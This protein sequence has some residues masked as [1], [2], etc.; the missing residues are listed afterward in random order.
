[1]RLYAPVLRPCVRPLPLCR[2]SGDNLPG[3]CI[4]AATGQYNGSCARCVALSLPAIK[5]GFFVPILH[6]FCITPARI[7]SAVSV[8]LFL[9]SFCTYCSWCYCRFLPFSA[10]YKRPCRCGVYIPAPL[11]KSPCAALY[12]LMRRAAPIPADKIKSKG[13]AGVRCLLLSVSNFVELERVRVSCN[14]E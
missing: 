5:G 3:I 10:A 14:M 1:M 9:Y 12:A 6:L 13:L 4:N 11:I 7:K 8:I 2:R